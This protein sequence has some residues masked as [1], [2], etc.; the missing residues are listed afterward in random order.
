MVRPVL[1]CTS[2]MAWWLVGSERPTNS[3]LPRRQSGM[4]R[5][6]R[7][8]FS[9]TSSLGMLSRSMLLRS[10]KAT[11]NCSAASSVSGRLFTSLFCT[12]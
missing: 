11:P 4:T 6:W 12:R 2:V 3:L 5:C 1:N 10:Q 8:S 9:L 7:T